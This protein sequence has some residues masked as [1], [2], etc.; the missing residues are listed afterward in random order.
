[1]ELVPSPTCPRRRGSLPLVLEGVG[2]YVRGV[3]PTPQPPPV[4]CGCGGRF[5]VVMVVME[6]KGQAVNRENTYYIR[7]PHHDPADQSGPLTLFEGPIFKF[8]SNDLFGS[9]NDP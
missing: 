7:T 6:M 8:G 1:M 9:R 2:A 5:V 4:G 3:R